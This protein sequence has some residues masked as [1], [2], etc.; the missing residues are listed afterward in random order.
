L[1]NICQDLFLLELGD[2]DAFHPD[3]LL[4]T[5]LVWAR[6]VTLGELET[7]LEN[8]IDVVVEGVEWVEELYLGH[9][10]RKHSQPAHKSNLFLEQ[11]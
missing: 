5:D 4:S 1:V 6:E 8:D 9:L 3:L 11:F 7:Y 10:D 2:G